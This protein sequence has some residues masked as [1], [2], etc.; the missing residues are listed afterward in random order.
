MFSIVV[1]SDV[2]FVKIL[3]CVQQMT[4]SI[5]GSQVGDDM[6]TVFER[7]LVAGQQLLKGSTV[8]L[9]DRTARG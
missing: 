6:A 4:C 9:V 5:L 7:Q 3:S 1:L 2:F 8:P